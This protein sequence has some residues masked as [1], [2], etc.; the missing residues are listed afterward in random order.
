MLVHKR[1]ATE[2]E[3]LAGTFDAIEM[4]LQVFLL[5]I[6]SVSILSL[7]RVISRHSEIMPG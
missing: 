4:H 3:S 2:L 7:K 1:V 6:R 5:N